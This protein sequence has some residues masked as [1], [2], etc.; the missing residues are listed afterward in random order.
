VL[1]SLSND[2]TEH[3]AH[4]TE[5]R[6]LG[7]GEEA[8]ATWLLEFG[9]DCSGFEDVKNTFIYKRLLKTKSWEILDT[10]KASIV[11]YLTL[12]FY[13]IFDSFVEAG[14]LSDAIFCLI[15]L[16]NITLFAVNLLQY[17]A[18]F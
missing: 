8:A 13:C 1:L 12:L 16:P 3:G 6:I 14:K 11:L 2:L 5:N 4:S 9:L 18:C 15:F 10:I 7:V 17:A